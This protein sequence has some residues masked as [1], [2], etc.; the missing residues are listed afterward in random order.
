M[1]DIGT[2]PWYKRPG[3]LLGVAVVLAFGL[4]LI[5]IVHLGVIGTVVQG[6]SGR[7]T[8]DRNPDRSG[9]VMYFYRVEEK[10]YSGWRRGIDYG[11][12]R[13]AVVYSPVIPG[14]HAT[15]TNTDI[16]TAAEFWL[17]P[18]F[19]LRIALMLLGI[20]VGFLIIYACRQFRTGTWR[21]MP[22][23]DDRTASETMR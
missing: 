12:Q 9:E 13:L 23:L 11:G 17:E 10:T 5:G 1:K 7:L 2:S 21:L 6:E 14:L 22:E 19:W 18:D 16:Q 4:K 3:Q 20:A 15:S 8:S